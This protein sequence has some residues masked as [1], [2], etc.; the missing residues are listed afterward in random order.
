MT[1]VAALVVLLTS[2]LIEY[3]LHRWPMHRRRK[4]TDALFKRHTLEH[5]RLF[6]YDAMGISSFEEVFLTTFNVSDVLVALLSMGTVGAILVPLLGL[7][8]AMVVAAILGF[9]GTFK[10]LIHMAFHLPENWMKLPVL[11]SRAF[12]WLKEHHAIHHDPKMMTRW[13]FNIG[14]PTF[15]VLF[16]TLRWRRD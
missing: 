10:Q 7:K 11:R 1:W 12:Y 14:L 15:D 8:G 2:D 6:T 16:G 9:Y 13:N 3:S 4:T 5:H